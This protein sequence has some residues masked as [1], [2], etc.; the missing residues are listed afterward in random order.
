MSQ[1]VPFLVSRTA[2][3]AANPASDGEMTVCR[4]VQNRLRILA[5]VYSY[6]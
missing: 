4:M 6:P 5:P 3:V 2:D 1:D